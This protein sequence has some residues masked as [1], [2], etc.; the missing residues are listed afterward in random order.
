[1]T[2]SRLHNFFSVASR[3][4]CVC[5]GQHVRRSAAI[6]V[7]MEPRSC[8]RAPSVNVFRGVAGLLVT[9]SF[10]GTTSSW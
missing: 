10:A 5:P 4:S 1:M 2:W 7:R 6:A 8:R 3:D 9:A